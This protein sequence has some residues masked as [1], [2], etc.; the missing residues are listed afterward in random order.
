MNDLNILEHIFP[1]VTEIRKVP[2]NSHHHL[3]LI[4]HSI[5]T[6]NQVQNF[7]DMACEEVKNIWMKNLFQDKN[8]LHI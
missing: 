8:V 6:V 2:K 5:E 1:E 3:C 7:Y 4:E